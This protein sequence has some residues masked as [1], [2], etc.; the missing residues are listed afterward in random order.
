MN[1]WHIWFVRLS[2][3]QPLLKHFIE[4]VWPMRFLSAKHWKGQRPTGA[5]W[6]RLNKHYCSNVPS[7]L[8][9]FH[10]W[11]TCVQWSPLPV[12][13]Q[14]V[15]Y[16]LQAWS[17]CTIS[18]LRHCR[19]CDL[20]KWCKDVKDA[21]KK[22]TSVDLKNTQNNVLE[23]VEQV[24]TCQQRTCLCS[25]RTTT[26]KVYDT[27]ALQEFSAAPSSMNK[28]SVKM[29]ERRA[30]KKWHQNL[31]VAGCCHN[32]PLFGT[33]SSNCWSKKMFSIII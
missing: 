20:E 19:W 12:S 17:H 24:R 4:A 15:K 2:V 18:I 5:F 14:P 32:P 3:T 23:S 26:L 30:P 6:K 28:L 25:L 11:S 13:V 1:C 21:A 22:Q 29:D 8:S 27:T 7:A 9:W 10:R 16:W 33:N 31:L